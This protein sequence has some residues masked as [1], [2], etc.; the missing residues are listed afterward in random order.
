MMLQMELKVLQFCNYFREWRR[1]DEW[2][3]F[4]VNPLVIS[5]DKNIRYKQIL[6][7]GNCFLILQEKCR[8]IYCFRLILCAWLSMH[9]HKLLCCLSIK[10]LLQSG[11]SLY[12]SFVCELFIK[13]GGLSEMIWLDFFKH[14]RQLFLSANPDDA[15]DFVCERTDWSAIRALTQLAPSVQVV[16]AGMCEYSFYMHYNI[17]LSSF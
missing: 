4:S 13:C 16:S 8:Q 3:R 6:V 14:S 17:K 9:H 2:F 10:I 12:E 7:R 15:C 5:L 11:N 1:T